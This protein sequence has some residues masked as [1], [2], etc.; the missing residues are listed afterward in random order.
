MEMS[1]RSSQLTKSNLE[2]FSI[3]WLD[4]SVNLIQE[5]LDVQQRIRATINH[6]EIFSTRDECEQYIR[7]VHFDDQIIFIVDRQSSQDIVP[8]IHQLPQISSIYIYCLD[9][10]KYDPWTKSFSKIKNVIAHVDELIEQIQLDQIKRVHNRLNETLSIDFF[11]AN[12]SSEQSSTTLNGQFIHSQL[13]INCLLR[14]KLTINDKNELISLCKEEYNGNPRQLS[15]VG[16]FETNYSPDRAVWWYTRDSFLYKV[17]N[18]ALR[19]QNI[20]V[21]F[22]FRFFLRDLEL[23]LKQ[24]KCSSTIRVYRGQLISKNELN[25]L[26]ASIGQFISMNSFLSTTIDRDVALF[27][28]G[29]THSLDDELEPILF[30]IDVDPRPD[31]T[32]PVADITSLSYFRAEQEVLIMLG[33]IFRLTDLHQDE[34]EIWIG[35]MTLCSDNDHHLNQVFEFMKDE[36]GT[37]ETDLLSFGHKLKDMGR[38]DDAGKY[39]RRLLNE[40]PCDHKDVPRCYHNLGNMAFQKG[41]YD[42]SLQWYNK[43]LEIWNRTL[44]ANDP[45]LATS[46]NNIGLVYDDQNDS[47]KALEMYEKA[48]QIWKQKFGENHANVAKCYNNIGVIYRKEKNYHTALNYYQKALTILQKLLPVDHPDLGSPH[49]CIANIY[50]YIG[51]YD[52]ALHYHEQ[53]HRIKLKTLPSQHSSIANTLENIGLVYEYKA[54]LQ[55][56]LSYYKNASDMFHHTLPSTHPSVIKVEQSVNRILSKIASEGALHE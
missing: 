13:L 30:E 33:S 38:F 56:S 45:L 31:G 55:R 42:S 28:I 29:D 9:K 32:K 37:G 40:L 34:N 24:Y 44:E 23:Q 4:T 15:I 26:K 39:Y 49:S 19:T 35:Q 16:E 21:L 50:Y 41:D 47:K 20:D 48:L 6:L 54:D 17:F 51:E 7:S 36:Y 12:E 27:F 25:K 1:K 43:S 11:H 46:Y 14:M 53:A 3:V 22:L 2:I 18:K 8:D 5:N 52:L 10:Q